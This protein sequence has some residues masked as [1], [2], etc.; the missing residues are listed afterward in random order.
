MR[1]L[2]SGL[3]IRRNVSTGMEL[4]TAVLGKAELAPKDIDHHRGAGRLAMATN[5]NFGA[6]QL[7]FAKPGC[8][9][10]QPSTAQFRIRD[11]DFLLR[12]RLRLEP[13]SPHNIVVVFG[14]PSDVALLGRQ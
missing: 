13:Y 7:D 2:I 6:S 14:L 1:P 5:L 9:K 11:G 10:V 12:L 4:Q 8:M 3:P